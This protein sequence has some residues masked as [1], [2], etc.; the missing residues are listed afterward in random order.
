M[1]TIFEEIEILNFKSLEMKADMQRLYAKSNVITALAVALGERI[2]REVPE[3]QEIILP[4]IESMKAAADFLK[5][6]F[7]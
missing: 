3:Q 2:I 5:G 1:R 7:E 6:K 4:Y